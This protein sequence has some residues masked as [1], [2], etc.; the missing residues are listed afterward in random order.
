MPASATQIFVTVYLDGS[1][2]GCMGSEIGNLSDDLRELT[3][4]ALADH[5][6]D[7]TVTGR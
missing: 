6:F 5:R 3:L 4:A 7:E 1:I 2:R